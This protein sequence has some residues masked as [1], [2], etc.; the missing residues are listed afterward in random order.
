MVGISLAWVILS[1]AVSASAPP[2]AL[3][4][5]YRAKKA[6]EPRV[7]GRL[8]AG[9]P[10]PDFDV[11]GLDGK[12]VRLADFRGRYVLLD[13]WA[14][15]C[16]PCRAELPGLKKLQE[17]YGGNKQFVLVS[18][19]L[20]EKMETLK[21]FV[22]KEGLKWTHGLLGEWKK[23]KI[24]EQ[25]GVRGIPELFLIDTDGEILKGGLTYETAR[26]ALADVLSDDER[27]SKKAA[28]TVK[29]SV[30]LPNGEPGKEAK[31]YIC[32]GTSTFFFREQRPDKE[33]NRRPN[34]REFLALDADASG[35]FEFASPKDP[36]SVVVFHKAG[37]GQAKEADFAG[38]PTIRLRPWARIRGLVTVPERAKSISLTVYAERDDR[39][40]HA[41]TL[42]PDSEGLYEIENVPSGG[43]AFATLLYGYDDGRYSYSMDIAPG[44]HLTRNY[45][46]EGRIIRGQLLAP[47]GAVDG[48]G[49]QTSHVDLKTESPVPEEVERQGKDAV[50]EWLKKW[51]E[52]AE[53]R[54]SRSRPYSHSMR[55]S[56]AGEF[57]FIEVPPGRYRVFRWNMNQDGYH[58]SDVFEVPFDRGETGSKEL[59]LGTIEMRYKSLKSEP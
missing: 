38:N 50:S 48:V 11:P 40:G 17:R 41:Q 36:Y 56:A 3:N 49:W 52:S 30:E 34:R 29:G 10:A 58:E 47:S 45:G 39:I 26:D 32:L 37:Y 19:S 12:P 22:D 2:D 57:R 16:G 4:Q 6:A 7:P 54:A 28:T 1:S 43:F 24:P 15:W 42:K 5:V 31:V 44:E 53:G 14:T 23:T 18:L 27:S 51:Q 33:E 8:M 59:D 21:A 13:F 55:P 46:G 20:D 25:Y 35:R 9:D